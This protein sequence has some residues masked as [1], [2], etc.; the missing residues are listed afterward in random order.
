MAGTW[1]VCI[2]VPAI[3]IG[4]Y[5]VV[6]IFWDF[7]VELLVLWMTGCS[8]LMFETPSLDISHIMI[9]V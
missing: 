1:L 3:P 9:H 5:R 4:Q 2:D 6:A 8:M 7:A